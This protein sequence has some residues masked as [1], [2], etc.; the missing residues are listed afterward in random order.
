MNRMH[1]LTASWLV[2]AALTISCD[3]GG[4]S[5]R[6][7]A[8]PFVRTESR[9]AC[10]DYDALKRPLFGDLHVHTALS[11]DSYI[12]DN[13]NIP[14]DAYRFGRGEAIRLEPLDAD[15]H[16]TR[17]VQ[18]ERPLDFMADTDHADL[19]AEVQACTDP[20]S[21][22]YDSDRCVV[23]REG[24]T[25]STVAWGMSLVPTAPER[26]PAVCGKSGIDC[27]AAAG[28]VWG[29][30]QRAAE[31]Y[32]D[33]TASC[34]FTTFVGYEWSGANNLSSIH[35]NVIFR[36]AE[37]PAL[38]ITHFEQPL[39]EGLWSAL[40]EQCLDA[41]TGCDVL[42]IPHNSN[43]SNGRL[44][45]T[46]YLGLTDIEDQRSQA[47]RRA[48]VEPLMEVF[49]HKGESECST[50]FPF[51]GLQA[52]P[53]ELC[54]FEEQRPVADNCGEGEGIG[55]VIGSGNGCVSYRDFLRGALLRGMAEEMRLGVN[56]FRLGVIASTD[57]HNAT[58][59]AAE[60]DRWQGHSGDQED[61]PVKR[62][63]PASL[64]PGGLANNPGGLA[65]VWA[66][67]N[68][69]D[70]VFAALARR[71]T[72]GTSGP[73]IAPRFFGG[74][75]Y[76]GDLCAN[77]DLVRIG[78]RDGV[79]M[80]GELPKS[81]G[82]ASAPVFVAAALRDPD[83]TDRPGTPLQR[84]QIVKGW[85]DADG[86]PHERVFD[87]AGNASNGASVDLDTC[88]PRGTGYDELC[89]V[90]SDPTFEPSQHAYYYARVLENPTCRWSTRECL[91]L[92]PE[93]RPPAC[94][95]PTILKTG[96]ERAWTSPIWYEP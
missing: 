73:R 12:W 28:D 78:Y 80:G 49:Q 5:T 65:G 41:G 82:G 59:G 63:T 16:G 67:E 56:P 36:N 51:P 30:V 92:A 90:W 18:L 23:F 7:Q 40:E 1:K 57:T 62:L 3:N 35:R 11:F 22:V 25:S 6:E 19:F 87:V 72:F 94:S 15:G 74:W 61:T 17:V 50:Q 88:E 4:K 10:S 31:L 55:G 14:E 9:E 42:A 29:G 2:V 68:S 77:P 95:D 47:R 43:L 39:P 26:F 45:S 91:A 58:P 33:R 96:Q 89:S 66:E 20:R 44:F 8:P 84:I 93:S 54:A 83:L 81:P 52:G 85:I 79:A 38:P 64:L 24:S 32:Y 75:R 76:G 86:T 71:E 27:A 70:A 48:R 69:R 34:R 53:D 46:D 60:E 37:V 21:R 13:R